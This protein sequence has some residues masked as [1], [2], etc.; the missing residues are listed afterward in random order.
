MK[1]KGLL[2][3]E[4]YMARKYCR[5][6]LV[7]AIIFTAAS[8]INDFGL[9][10]VF[11]PCLLAGMIPSNLL[12]YDERSKWDVYSGGLPYTKAQLVSGKYLIGLL[13]QLLMLVLLGVAQA[14]RMHR[15]GVFSWDY[16]LPLLLTML[17]FSCV[18]SSVVL[19]FMFIWG[20]EKGRIAYFAMFGL[21]AA[22]ITVFAITTVS[23]TN[24]QA[25]VR[26]GVA[27]PLL[28]LGGIAVYA[29]SWFLSIV[30]YRNR[31]AKA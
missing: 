6:Y 20:A 27:L 30:F 23:E 14:I 28:L 1:L 17:V 26:S 7:I 22:S 15:D 29:L 21:A 5:A 19:P 18:A 13:A 25:I 4:F 3:K 24:L 10:Y 2:L 11:Y 31:D 8:A 16:Y 12:S 9:F